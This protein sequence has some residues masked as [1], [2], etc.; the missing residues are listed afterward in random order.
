M[1]LFLEIFL[2][3]R[4][5]RILLVS[6]ENEIIFRDISEND[7]ENMIMNNIILIGDSEIS[8]LLIFGFCDHEHFVWKVR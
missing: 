1:K 2:A 3:L 7:Y 6:R 5:F 4:K 8:D